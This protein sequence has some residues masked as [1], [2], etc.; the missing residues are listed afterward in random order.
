MRRLICR[1][2]STFN[3]LI[4]SPS[5]AHVSLSY[6]LIKNINEVSHI[7]YSPLEIVS[8]G[9]MT[10]YNRPWPL[11]CCCYEISK[12]QLWIPMLRARI[13]YTVH[14]HYIQ[15]MWIFFFIKTNIPIFLSEFVYSR[16]TIRYI[17]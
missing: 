10:E 2:P 4:L 9:R 12:G 13:Y 11:F 7:E 17:I 8:V 14:Y 16:T 5:S 1:R 15:S 6:L 3:A